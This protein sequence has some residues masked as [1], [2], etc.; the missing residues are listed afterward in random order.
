[1]AVSLMAGAALAG[2]L[3]KVKLKVAQAMMP[4]TSLTHKL[5]EEF[6][7]NVTQRSQVPHNSLI[8]LLQECHIQKNL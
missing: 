8:Q 4:K 6:A 2:N 1:M 3:P 5:I 7:A